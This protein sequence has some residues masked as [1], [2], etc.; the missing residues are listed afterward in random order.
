MMEKHTVRCVLSGVPR[1]VQSQSVATYHFP[2]GGRAL[3]QREQ[4]VKRV[5]ELKEDENLVPRWWEGEIT[6][7][8][9]SR[10]ESPSRRL[11]EAGPGTRQ[12]HPQVSTQKS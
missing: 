11:M 4:E 9:E 6:V 7:P 8:S 3:V 1:D 2:P 12:P 10:V 5:G